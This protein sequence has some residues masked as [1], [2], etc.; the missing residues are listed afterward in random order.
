MGRPL[1]GPGEPLWLAA[2]RAW[3]LALLEAEADACPQC[4][5]QWSQATTAAAE[6]QYTTELVRC[7]ACVAVERHLRQHER[8]GGSTAGLHVTATHRE[9]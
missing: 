4:G 2:D 1:P 5:T 6:D 8:D 9:E 7:H 3:A